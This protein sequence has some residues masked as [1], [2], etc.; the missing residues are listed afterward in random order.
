MEKT[1]EGTFIENIIKIIDKWS[2]E[3]CVYCEPGTL[4]TIEGMVEYKCIQCGKTMKNSDYLGEIA[5]L[6]LKYRKEQEDTF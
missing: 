1:I 4:A 5:K 3:F 2:F 6:V